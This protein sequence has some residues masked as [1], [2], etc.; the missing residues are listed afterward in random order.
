[1]VR[2]EAKLSRFS[3]VCFLQD[4]STSSGAAEGGQI[5]T[6]SASTG[7]RF[8]VFHQHAFHFGCSMRFLYRCSGM[9]INL[10]LRKKHVTTTV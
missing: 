1:M 9:A 10:A 4:F 8:A 7:V 5:V 6:G 2:S 3:P